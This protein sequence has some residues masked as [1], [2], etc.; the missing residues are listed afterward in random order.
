M[1]PKIAARTLTA[2]WDYREAVRERDGRAEHVTNASAKLKDLVR[3]L[4]GGKAAESQPDQK[5]RVDKTLLQR[6]SADL[7]AVSKIQPPQRRGF[8]FESFLKE[9]FDAYGMV[10]RGSFRLT[11][12]QIDGSFVLSDEPYLLEAR[13]QKANTDAADLRAFQGKC[14]EKASWT[15]GL[16][17]SRKPPARKHLRGWWKFP[18]RM[19]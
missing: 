1:D 4:D 15:C 3:R 11:G 9:L 2:L 7:L 17:L 10:A 13:W 16:F 18:V 12:E 5:P 8:A 6:M 19:A 14:E